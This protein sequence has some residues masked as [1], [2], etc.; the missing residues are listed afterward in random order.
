MAKVRWYL[1]YR[2]ESL[3]TPPYLADVQSDRGNAGLRA[4]LLRSG[5][6]ETDEAT[7]LRLRRELDEASS[8]LAVSR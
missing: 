5:C 1:G 2:R 7:A 3:N 6:V 8:T 4:A